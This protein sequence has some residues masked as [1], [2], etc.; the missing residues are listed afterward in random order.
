MTYGIFKRH[1]VI[2]NIN[3]VINGLDRGAGSP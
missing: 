3:A 2:K 1:A